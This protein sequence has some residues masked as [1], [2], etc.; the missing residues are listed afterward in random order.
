[1]NEPKKTEKPIIRVVEDEALRNVEKKE[2]EAWQ[3]E[4]DTNPM[5]QGYI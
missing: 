5:Y 1:M 3:K 2:I 4:I